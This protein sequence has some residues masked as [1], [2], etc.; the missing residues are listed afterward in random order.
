M[1]GYPTATKIEM[2]RT[3]AWHAYCHTPIWFKIKYHSIRRVHYNAH[4]LWTFV[5]PGGNLRK[6]TGNVRGAR[7]IR[8][9]GHR[10]RKSFLSQKLPDQ[11]R[12]HRPDYKTNRPHSSPLHKTF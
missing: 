10:N 7:I 8:I 11:P 1:V 2:E 12:Q 9:N 4:A 3:M 5:K 6:V